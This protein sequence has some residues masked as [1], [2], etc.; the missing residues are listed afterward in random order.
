M[1]AVCYFSYHFL[2]TFLGAKSFSAKIIEAL[3]PIALGGITFVIV[4]KLLRVSEV[5]KLFNTLKR[6][7]GRK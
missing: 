1:S 2:N 4:A 3:V 6:K 7:L 5:D